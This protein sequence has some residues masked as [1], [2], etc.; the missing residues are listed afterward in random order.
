MGDGRIAA[1]AGRRHPPFGISIFWSRDKGGSWDVDNPISV[2][3]GL[4]SRDLGYPTAALKTDGSLFV[5]Y[6]Y[7]DAGGVT[8]VHA[9]TV[10]I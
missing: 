8:G 3:S 7:R 2:R 4:P 6:Y 10:A 5:A 1:V 9:T